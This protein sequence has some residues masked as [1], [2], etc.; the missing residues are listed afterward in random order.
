M[1]KKLLDFKNSENN[2]RYLT[3]LFEIQI[4]QF[5][6]DGLPDTIPHE[7]LEMYLLINGNCAIGKPKGESEIYCAIGSYNGDYNGYLPKSYTAAVIGLDEISG[8]WYGQDK[9]IVVAKNNNIGIPE[10]DI[11]FTADVLNQIDI[12]EKMN[13]IFTRFA[14]IPFVENDKEKAQVESA[15]KSII[16]GDYTAIAS[17]DVADS[18]EKFIEGAAEKDKFLDLVDVDKVN[19]LQY[20]NQ[21]RDNV[22]KR[23]L[24]RR[25]YMVQTTAKLAQQTN[26]EMHGADSYAF[27]YP[28]QQLKQREKMCEEMNALFGLETSVH[29]NPILSKVYERY[30]KDDEQP[31]NVSRETPTEE[32]VENVSRETNDEN[33]EVKDGEN[34]DENN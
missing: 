29:F 10:F 33:P 16:R 14:R 31:E 21:Y 4:N 24:C 19:G 12:S 25:G 1:K 17:R 27:L 7:F 18:F 5:E 22:F 26:A 20:L 2:F 15:I 30:M 8:D 32:Q 11:P 28:L 34:N 23:F 13:V 6:Y 9:S 3:E